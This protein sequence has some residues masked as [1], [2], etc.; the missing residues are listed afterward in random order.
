MNP[1]A[2]LLSALK[3]KKTQIAISILNAN[4]KILN[5]LLD[6][7]KA[8]LHLAIEA[9]N[10]ELV[11]ALTKIQNINLNIKT[12][13]SAT[14]MDQHSPTVIACY[15]NIDKSILECLIQAGA[16]ISSPTR[17][18]QTP[19]TVAV[20]YNRQD[21]VEL[22]IASGKDIKV[23]AIISSGDTAVTNAADYASLEIMKLVLS[24]PDIT[25]INHKK[26][27]GKSALFIA[28]EQGNFDKVGLLS[29]FPGIDLATRQSLATGRSAAGIAREK[30]FF[31]VS[32]FITLQR[33]FRLNKVDYFKI[34]QDD[35]IQELLPKGIPL[36]N[37]NIINANNNNQGH[38]FS[39]FSWYARNL[40]RVPN[41]LL[42]AEYLSEI[43]TLISKPFKQ[44]NTSLTSSEITHIQARKTWSDVVSNIDQLNAKYKIENNIE[45]TIINRLHNLGYRKNTKKIYHGCL[46]FIRNNSAIVV[47]FNASFLNK[48]GLT[49]Y[50][51]L[52]FAE[53][54]G[55]NFDKEFFNYRTYRDLTEKHLFSSL[56]KHLKDSLNQKN[57]KPRYGR[58]VI[59]DRNQTITASDGY[60]KSFI[61]LQH[62]VK[63]LSLFNYRD[64][65]NA[66]VANK[67]IIPC[68]YHFMELL[69]FQ[70]PD[71]QLKAIANWVTTGSLPSSFFLGIEYI[72]AL[73]PAIYLSKD[74]I[75]QIYI[76][77]DEYVLRPQDRS[78]LAELG[79][80][81]TNAHKNPYPNLC[82][83]FMKSVE[84]NER[85]E[86]KTLLE[87]YP[88]LNRISNLKGLQPIHIAASKGYTEMVKL[89]TAFGADINRRSAE[90]KAPLHYA[91]ECGFLDLVDMITSLRSADINIK[92][93]TSS[94]DGMTPL[95]MASWLRKQAIFD[96]LIKKGANPS[97]ITSNGQTPLTIAALGNDKTIVRALIATNNNNVNTVISQGHTALT[98]AAEKGD[99]EMVQLILSISGISNVNH[100]KDNGE[101]ALFIAASRFDLDKITALLQFPGIDKEAK[102]LPGD[103]KTA[104]QILEENNY[105]KYCAK[106]RGPIVLSQLGLSVSSCRSSSFP[107][108]YGDCIKHIENNNMSEVQ[109]LIDCFPSL[110]RM[111]NPTGQ[112]LI[113]IAAKKGYLGLIS[114]LLKNGVDIN[115]PTSGG[116][117]ALQIAEEAQQYELMDYL[118]L[119]MIKNNFEQEQMLSEFMFWKITNIFNDAVKKYI[120]L[121][122]IKNQGIENI[123]SLIKV[124]ETDEK[125]TQKIETFLG[126]LISENR[127]A[128]A[129]HQNQFHSANNTPFTL[130]IDEVNKDIYKF[131]ESN[132]WDVTLLKPEHVEATYNSYLASL[133]PAPEFIV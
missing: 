127:K 132:R 92:S 41:E 57:A 27:D 72:E 133:P 119:Q 16:D 90:G 118:K 48:E 76:H 93:S 89:L 31:S 47:T 126:G 102:R 68:T 70:W 124:L 98:N 7:G 2:K 110:T 131:L 101:S 34:V 21:C 43:V 9:N 85:V 53:R 6:N 30:G 63:F 123:V 37:E 29:K 73:V 128:K 56:D 42:L 19:L 40:R 78:L 65:V 105:Q 58:V 54:G 46:D 61:V 74:L 114:L 81:E 112:E 3:N 99:A 88:L 130:L 62:V 35:L 113:H 117:T 45:T 103:G 38:L 106:P 22:L 10:L 20:F 109:K 49:H 71:E 107:V 84:N 95:L 23:N 82:S 52:N 116:K 125:S 104:L 121:N 4:P 25:I 11:I 108:L 111:I 26:N 44:S 50:Q 17:N 77:P 66:I 8:A 59:L 83:S 97:L 28:A 12:S 33:L 80:K 24:V 69:L 32:C 15:K 129:A 100:K 94:C 51:L 79:I 75:E 5:E 115:Q 86:I 1:K 96:L 36:E 91:V 64:S 87:T 122:P 14:N 13:N 39:S 120:L 60:G 55:N 67:S 18:G